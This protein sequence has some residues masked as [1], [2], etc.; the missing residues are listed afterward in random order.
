M[1]LL[2]LNAPLESTGDWVTIN[3]N[4]TSREK[5]YG[6]SL[7]QKTAP[8]RLIK[9]GT[10]ELVSICFETRNKVDKHDGY[11]GEIWEQMLPST[12]EQP[13]DMT[14]YT[15]YTDYYTTDNYKTGYYSPD[16]YYTYS[17]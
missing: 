12:L 13:T 16:Y 4:P 9:F 17:G 10:D 5:Y 2:Q 11:V 14:D 3:P 8:P 6:V 15:D 1:F 7:K